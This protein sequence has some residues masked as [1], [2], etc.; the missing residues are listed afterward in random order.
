VIRGKVNRNLM[1]RKGFADG[2]VSFRRSAE[3]LKDGDS[4]AVLISWNQELKRFLYN[5]RPVVTGW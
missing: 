2:E 5:I 3:K 4:L 1:T